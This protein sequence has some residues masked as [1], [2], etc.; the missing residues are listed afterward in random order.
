MALGMDTRQDAEEDP[1]SRAE[2]A[3]PLRRTYTLGDALQT[4]AAFVLPW[5]FV[6]RIFGRIWR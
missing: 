1:H 3:V 2:S 6:G 4:G 5:I